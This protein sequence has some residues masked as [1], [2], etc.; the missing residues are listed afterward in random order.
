[1]LAPALADPDPVLIFEHGVALQRW[2]ASCRPTPARS[3]S[4]ARRCA[5]AARDVSLITYGGTLPK[6]LAA[7]E[8]LAARGRSR[9]R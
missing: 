4:S 3:T 6:A 5:A 8:T 1:M 9:P 7:A 2:R